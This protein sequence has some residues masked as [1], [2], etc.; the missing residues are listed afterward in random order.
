MKNLHKAIISHFLLQNIGMDESS[1]WGFFF[2][3]TARQLLT[4]GL[5]SKQ[6]NLLHLSAVLIHAS[7]CSHWVKM[8]SSVVSTSAAATFDCTHP[9]GAPVG[10]SKDQSD[11]LV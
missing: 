1:Q 3:E 10:P 8:D 2:W 6:V 11:F 9:V 7:I 5:I 4:Q